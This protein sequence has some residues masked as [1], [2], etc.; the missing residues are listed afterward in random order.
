M[1]LDN[2]VAAV[3]QVRAVLSIPLIPLQYAVSWPIEFFDQLGGSISSRDALIKEN[4]NLKAEQLRLKAQVQRL[5]ALELENNQLKALMSSSAEVQGKVLIAQLLAVATEPFVNQVLLDKGSNDGVYVGQPVLDANGVMGKVIQISPLTSRV[6]LINDRHSG[7]PVQVA[8]NGIR[9]IAVG[10]AF[11]GQLRLMHVPQT[12]DVR[13]GD[14]LITS[15]LGDHFP[16]GYPVGQ[17][18]LVEKDPGLQFATISIEPTAHLDRS[19][20]VLLVWPSKMI[21]SKVKR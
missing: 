17:V 1:I 19:R 11:T 20:G 18:T 3:S 4:F 2:R 6:L 15:G 10:D 21:S 16:E 8:R 5:R 7:V 14:M 12:A 13:T 9:A